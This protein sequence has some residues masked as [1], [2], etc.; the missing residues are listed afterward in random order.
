MINNKKLI[1]LIITDHLSITCSIHLALFSG[2]VGGVGQEHQGGAENCH[3]ERDEVRCWMW[4][5]IKSCVI[6]DTRFS[7]L[8]GW[9]LTLSYYTLADHFM[10]TMMITIINAMITIITIMAKRL[11]SIV[12]NSHHGGNLTLMMMVGICQW[13]NPTIDD[14][15]DDYD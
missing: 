1:I 15:D 14:D 8:V 12:T 2:G 5:L 11:I 9:N 7:L 4:I 10:R 6:H 3:W 13:Q